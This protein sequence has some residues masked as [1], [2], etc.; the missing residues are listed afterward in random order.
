RT[1]AL[2]GADV[3]R[4]DPPRLPELAP[5]HLDTGHGKRSALLDAAAEPS[6]LAA[7]LDAADAVV[8]GYRRQALGRLGLDPVGLARRHPQLVVAQL[9][10]WSPDAGPRGFDS[11]V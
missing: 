8:L 9:S 11:I 7:L 6:G 3:L 10:A 4:I 1:L 5:Q 2:A